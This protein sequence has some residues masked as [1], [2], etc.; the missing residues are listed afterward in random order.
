[1][2]NGTTMTSNHAQEIA[3]GERFEFGANWEAFLSTLNDKRIQE[4]ESSLKKMLGTDTLQGKS[5]LDIGSGSGL[6]S[7]AA[8]RLGAIVHSFDY[9]PQSVNCTRQLKERYFKGDSTWSIE[10]GSALDTKYIQSLGVFDVVYSWGVLHHTGDM[11]KAL[12]NAALPVKENGLLFIAIYNDQGFASSI[13][14]K[15]K[16][17]YCSGPL[18]KL[19]VSAVYVPY[20][21]TKAIVAGVIKYRNPF[22]QFTNY[23][24]NRGMSIYHDWVDWLGGYPFEV[25]TPEYLFN[26]YQKKGFTL[27]NLVTTNRLGCNELVLIKL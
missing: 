4:A 9:D 26:L 27:K 17:L 7:L 20:F 15:V 16:K 5:F 3:Q 11:N 18:G 13:W 19:A 21:T 2:L 22:G 6:F 25:A 1:M 12:E 14:K 8:K 23:K 24:N 10:E